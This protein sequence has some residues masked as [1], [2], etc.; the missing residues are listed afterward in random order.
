MEIKT[1]KLGPSPLV[2]TEL[3]GR[4][5]SKLLLIVLNPPH[6]AKPNTNTLKHGAL[7]TL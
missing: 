5:Q 1:K 2:G 6:S 7:I 4:Q 3:C